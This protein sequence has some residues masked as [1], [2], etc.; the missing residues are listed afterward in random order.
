M[1][2]DHYNNLFI[3]FYIL[4][5]STIFGQ[6]FLIDYK[7]V[8]GNILFSTFFASSDLPFHSDQRSGQMD[9]YL[10]EIPGGN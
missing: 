9:E 3:W 6:S 10:Q 4:L 5:F 8:V 7:P 1:A 2:G